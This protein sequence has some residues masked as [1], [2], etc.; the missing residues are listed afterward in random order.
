VDHDLEAETSSGERGRRGAPR[1]ARAQADLAGIEDAVADAE[2]LAA[3][4]ERSSDRGGR[5]FARALFVLARNLRLALFTE[6]PEEVL[7]RLQI[8]LE[9]TVR[10]AAADRP[11]AAPPPTVPRAFAPMKRGTPRLSGA[12][13][14]PVAPGQGEPGKVDP[15]PVDPLHAD[16]DAPAPMPSELEPPSQRPTIPYPPY[17]EPDAAIEVD[18]QPGGALGSS[19]SQIRRKVTLDDARRGAR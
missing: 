12:P 9:T 1:E 5:L 8:K 13:R 10:L 4:L 17:L 3:E 6:A 11:D 18:S 2:A 16:R 7:T 15:R 19:I 14:V